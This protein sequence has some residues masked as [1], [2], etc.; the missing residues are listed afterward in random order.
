L[1]SLLCD[2][3]FFLILGQFRLQLGVLRRS[4]L[5]IGLEHVEQFSVDCS[6]GRNAQ[7]Q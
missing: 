7:G 3:L 6:A 5:A 2:L 1:L 4:D